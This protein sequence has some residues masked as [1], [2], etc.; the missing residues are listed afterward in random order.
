VRQHCKLRSMGLLGAVRANTAVGVSPETFYAYYYCYYC[1]TDLAWVKWP[2][3]LTCY[4]CWA[5]VLLITQAHYIVCP[6]RSQV[7]MAMIVMIMI[8]QIVMMISVQDE[9]SRWCEFY[10]LPCFFGCCH[11]LTEQVWSGPS[12]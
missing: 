1:V 8:H 12:A 10:H 4:D 9:Y 11:P 6:M 2:A 7:M 5:R 3:W